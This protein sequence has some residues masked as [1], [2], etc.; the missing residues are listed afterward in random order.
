MKLLEECTERT[1]LS[2]SNIQ[3][4]FGSNP[5]NPEIK[6][7]NIQTVFHQTTE[8]LPGKESNKQSPS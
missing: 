5:N 1:L 3:E 8:L 7:Q 6:S 4:L 2:I